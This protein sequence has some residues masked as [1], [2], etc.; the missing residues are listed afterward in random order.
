MGWDT[1]KRPIGSDEAEDRP[2]MF[3]LW[4]QA[5]ALAHWLGGRLPTPLEW[6]KAARGTDSRLYPWGDTWNP[7]AGHFRTSE[8]HEGGDSEKRK[9]RL[10]AV[11]AYPEG[12]SPYGVMDMVGNLG[13]WHALTGE[14]SVGYM[15]Y[16]IKEMLRRTPWFWALPMHCRGG[17]R[18]QWMWYVGCRPVLE[19]WGR[20]L[21]P[22]YRAELEEA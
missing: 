14:N 15:G 22:G 17:T 18:R 3:M 5:Q 21:W 20:H 7:S 1:K 13:E 9:G 10:T 16:S 6:E 8:S 2:E 11:D 12:A 4:E 19:E